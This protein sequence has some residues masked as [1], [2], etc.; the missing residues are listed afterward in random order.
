M[1]ALL[2]RGN[3]HRTGG[4]VAGT[5]GVSNVYGKEKVRERAQTLARKGHHPTL[6]YHIKHLG[7]SGKPCRDVT[8]CSLKEKPLD[9]PSESKMADKQ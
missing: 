3:S 7:L 9:F 2:G 5:G 4:D 1:R 8:R 6:G